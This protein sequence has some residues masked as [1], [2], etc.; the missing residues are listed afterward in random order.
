MQINH[1]ISTKFSFDP[2][3]SFLAH[4]PSLDPKLFLDPDLEPIYEKVLLGK[5]LSAEDGLT[6]YQ[7]NNLLGIGF[8]ANLVRER[9]NGQDAYYVYNQHLN[10]TNICRNGCSFCAFSRREGEEGAYTMSLDEIADKIRSRLDEP[11]TEVH[12]VGGLNEK[13]PYS[14][15]LEMLATIKRIRPKV[16]IQA[17]TAVE[18]AYLAELSNQSPAETLLELQAA[19]LGSLPG[20]GAE[21]FSSRVRQMVCPKKLPANEWLEIMRVAH[22]LGIRSN[23]TMLYGHIETLKERVEH[24][25]ALRQVQDEYGGFLAFIPLAFH[26]HNTKLSSLKKTSGFDDLKNIAVA[27]LLL[28]NFAHIKPF[29]IMVTPKIAQIALSFGADDLDGTVIEERITHMAGGETTQGLPQSELIRLI[30]E[31]GRWPKQRDTL[32]NLISEEEGAE[33]QGHNSSLR[34]VSKT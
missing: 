10:Y 34:V 5:R 24:L 32:Y 28:D 18:I 17:F 16:H 14:Y 12:I 22:R 15:Y 21:I 25:L 1:D 27:R 8:L 33:A 30:R 13:L 6:L 7:S 23:A 11:I 2:T 19:G 29:W 20:G 3:E 9:I 26:P 4:R 31:A